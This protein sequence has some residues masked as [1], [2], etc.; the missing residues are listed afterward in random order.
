M[1]ERDDVRR[2]RDPAWWAGWNTLTVTDHPT[3][4]P[5]ALPAG[6][7]QRALAG[8]RSE[9]WIQLPRPYPDDSVERLRAGVVAL[10]ERRLP[11]VFIWVF[12]ETWELFGRLD[13]VLREV[14]GEP[15]RAL[16]CFW[17]WYLPADPSRAGWPPHRDRSKGRP[18]VLADGTPR[19]MTAWI[20]LG[21]ATPANGCMYVVPARFGPKE[22]ERIKPQDARALPAE[23]GEVLAWRQDIWHWGGRSSRDA[24]EPR[25]SVGLE[26][27]SGAD[28]VYHGPLLD[29]THPPPLD[30]RLALIGA[31][32]LRYRGFVKNAKL[33]TLGRELVRCA[34]EL[35]HGPL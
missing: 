12:D 6:T 1:S 27:Q 3:V 11:A 2:W 5:V 30:H 25:I 24:E 20:P 16:P 26:F 7:P 29:P 13:P 4:S 34:P 32:I 33:P 22:R 31:N 28:I 8:L 15:Y 10:R 23:P 21:R 17:A 18:N 19:T 14:L 35:D 9:G